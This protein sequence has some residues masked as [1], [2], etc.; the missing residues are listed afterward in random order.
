[1]SNLSITEKGRR[2]LSP[3]QWI[4]VATFI[5]F[6]LSAATASAAPQ[7]IEVCQKGH[8]IRVDVHAVPA[9]LDQGAR[10]GSCDGGGG[11]ACSQE[12]DPVT[13]SDGKT[14]ANECFATCAG[15]TGCEHIGVCSNI[16]NPVT[17]NG[18]TYANACQARL[19]GATGCTTLCACPLDY[20]PVRCD[21]GKV[22]INACVANC[23]GHTNCTPLTTSP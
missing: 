18:V 1:M 14:Y 11:C 10:L 8:T 2:V 17:C 6:G 12:F 7:L 4:A 23:N 5:V 9:L 16:W 21:D 3:A 22:Y 15:S 13:C 19:A 20:A